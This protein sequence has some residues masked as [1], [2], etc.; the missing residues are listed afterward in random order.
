MPVVL[1][2]FEEHAVARADNLDRP[3]AALAE[4]HALGDVDGLPEGVGVPRGPRARCE[5]DVG[6]PEAGWP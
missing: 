5:V 6:G 2:R 4:A 3:T 1:A